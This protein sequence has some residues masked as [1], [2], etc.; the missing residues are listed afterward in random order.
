MASI[1]GGDDPSVAWGYNAWASN[2]ISETLTGLSATATVGSLTTSI[3]PGWGTLNWGENGWGSVDSATET[4]TGLSA[5]SSLGS[6]GA[7]P[8]QLMGLT[9]LDADTGTPGTLSV[10]SSLTLTL[11]GIPAASDVG[12]LAPADVM[13]L[14]GLAADTGT[15]GTITTTQLT[16]GSLV[17]LGLDAESK[18]GS[19]TISSNPFIALTGLSAASSL[20]TVTS[21]AVTLVTLSGLSA[22]SALGTVTST[23][24]TNASLVGLGLSAAASVGAIKSIRAYKDIDITGYTS[25]TDVDHVAQEKNKLCLQHI[26]NQVSN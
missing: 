1:W 2:T 5:A 15:P 19:V 17:G 25:Y 24:Q 10:S 4:L 16:N 23:Q 14:T 11:T 8:D 6:L 20:G 13:A 9:G 26:M 21:T 18:V 3:Q 22:A 7:I 12:A